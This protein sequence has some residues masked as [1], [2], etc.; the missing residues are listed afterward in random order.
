MSFNKNEFDIKKGFEVYLPNLFKLIEGDI[1]WRSIT[2]NFNK[3]YRRNTEKYNKGEK[4]ELR[5]NIYSIIISAEKKELNGINFLFF[6]N[7]LLLDLSAC[8]NKA[9]KR[10]IVTN[11]RNML[12]FHMDFLHYLGELALLNCFMQTGKY[13]L[14]E[15]EYTENKKTS[16]DFKFNNKKNG[17]SILIEVVNF[18]LSDKITFDNKEIRKFL[19]SKLTQKLINTDKGGIIN[20]TLVPI[21]WGGRN[22]IDNII[23]VKKFYEETNFSMERVEIP[24]VY[25]PYT[26]ND[27]TFYKFG[28]IINIFKHDIPSV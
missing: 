28:S 27:Q 22:S 5:I 10:R 8:L 11:I 16:I 20:Y 6:I 19:E 25:F 17:E 21:L 9:E 4:V 2:N 15:T 7:N 23:R 18:E 3:E 26:I 1:S 12:Y 24:I 13:E 14:V